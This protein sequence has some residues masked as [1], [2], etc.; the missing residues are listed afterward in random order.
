VVAELS[1]RDTKQ[2]VR[3]V[4]ARELAIVTRGATHIDVNGWTVQQERALATARYAV[5]KQV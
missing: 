3:P 2:G 1:A 5:F 4:L